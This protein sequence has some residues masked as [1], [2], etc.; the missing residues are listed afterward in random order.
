M[1]DSFAIATFLG[2]GPTADAG[3]F[4]DL[5]HQTADRCGNASEGFSWA[6]GMLADRDLVKGNTVAIDA[7]TLEANAAMRSIVRRDN[8]AGY[9]E[10]LKVWRRNR[11]SDADAG[12]TGGLDRKRTKKGAKTTGS[13]RRTRTRRS[14]R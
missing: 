10:F 11:E 2:F 8:G 9:D 4:D 13:I 12:R 1:A 14:R 6:L 7:T 3:S 5:A